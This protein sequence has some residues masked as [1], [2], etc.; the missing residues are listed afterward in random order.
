[1]I[2][3]DRLVTSGRSIFCP[4]AIQDNIIMKTEFEDNEYTVLIHANTEVYFSDDMLKSPKTEHN[5]VMHTL[6]NSII[7]GAFM[8]LKNFTKIGRNS[9]YFDNKTV[10]LFA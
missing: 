1:M 7:N 10:S 9:K 5:T 3:G 6:I 4:E 8:E 2:M